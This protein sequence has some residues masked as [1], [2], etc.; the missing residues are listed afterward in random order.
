MSL[1]RQNIFKM[2]NFVDMW[3]IM[4]STSQKLFL[5]GKQSMVFLQGFLVLLLQVLIV[6]VIIPFK[7]SRTFSIKPLCSE[8]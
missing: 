8:Q 6:W 5:L 4:S 7:K 2:Q 1:S 3:V